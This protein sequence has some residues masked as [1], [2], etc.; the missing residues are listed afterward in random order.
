MNPLNSNRTESQQKNCHHMRYAF[1]EAGHT[2]AGHVTGRCISK[3]SIVADGA[4]GYRSDGNQAMLNAITAQFGTGPRQ[5]CVVHKMNNVHSSTSNKQQEQIKPELH[6]LFYQRDRQ[7][8][9]QAVAVLSRNTDQSIPVPG[10]GTAI[11]HGG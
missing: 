10:R 6:A 11:E 7:A 4:R 2:V 3:E 1:H 9:D 8:A 5:R